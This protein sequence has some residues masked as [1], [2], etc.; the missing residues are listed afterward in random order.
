MTYAV[1][2]PSYRVTITVSC[3]LFLEEY[4]TWNRTDRARSSAM[5]IGF[6]HFIRG[7]IFGMNSLRLC[8]VRPLLSIAG[9]GMVVARFLL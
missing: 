3:R 1:N 7:V 8:S 6:V 5:A 4:G 2:M 9:F